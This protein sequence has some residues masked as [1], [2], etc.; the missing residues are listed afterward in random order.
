MEDLIANFEK[1]QMIYCCK[2]IFSP[3]FSELAISINFVT[4]FRNLAEWLAR[5]NVVI[6]TE[7][8][9]LESRA[10]ENLLENL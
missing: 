6:V 10:N 3:D 1:V 9:G 8:K 4:C 7:E 2:L 5:E